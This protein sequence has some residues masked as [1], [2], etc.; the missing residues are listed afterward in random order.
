[1]PVQQHAPTPHHEHRN[2]EVSAAP[3]PVH[4][5]QVF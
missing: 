4:G 5:L 3:S 1:V 2:R